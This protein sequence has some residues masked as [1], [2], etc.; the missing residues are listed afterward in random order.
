MTIGIIGTMKIFNIIHNK[1]TQFMK[2]I[3]IGAVHKL[4]QIV[5]TKYSFRNLDWK[6][7]DFFFF[8]V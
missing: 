6:K 3:K 2:K 4:A 7:S 5:G 8:I 1:L